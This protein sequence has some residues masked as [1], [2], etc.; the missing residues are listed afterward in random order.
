MS[1]ITSSFG[2]A[3][4][5]IRKIWLKEFHYFR[6]NHPIFILLF[7]AIF[8]V[9]YNVSWHKLPPSVEGSSDFLKIFDNFRVTKHK[10]VRMMICIPSSVVDYRFSTVAEAIHLTHLDFPEL[11]F[12]RDLDVAKKKLESGDIDILIHF[13]TLIETGKLIEYNIISQSGDL[14]K[15]YCIHC[16]HRRKQSWGNAVEAQQIVNRFLYWL[17]KARGFVTRTPH[18]QLS[19]VYIEGVDSDPMYAKRQTDLFFAWLMLLPICSR[20]IDSWNDDRKS[21]FYKIL[22]SLKIRRFEYFIAK[23]QFWYG[24]SLILSCIVFVVNVSVVSGVFTSTYLPFLIVYVACIFAFTIF[25]ATLFPESPFFAKFVGALL[26]AAGEFGFGTVLHGMAFFQLSVRFFGK[27]NV[28]AHWDDAVALMCMSFNFVLLLALSIYLDTFFFSYS[29]EPLK[30]YFPLER[31]Y[32]MPLSRSPQVDKHH[33]DQILS[34]SQDVALNNKK[35]GDKEVESKN[36]EQKTKTSNI[37]LIVL[38]GVCKRIKNNWKV[39]QLSLTIRYGEILTLYGHHGCGGEEILAIISGEMKPEYGEVMREKS[40]RELMVARSSHVPSVNYLNVKQYLRLVSQMRE[41]SVPE[42]VLDEMLAELDLTKVDRRSLDLLSTTQRERLRIAAAFVGQPDVVLIDWPTQESLPEWKYMILN[43]IEKRKEKKAIVMTSYDAEE[44]EAISD[45]VVLLSEGYVILNGACDNY[46]QSMSSVFEIRLWPVTFFTNEQI[47]KIISA[48]SMGDDQ[49]R[50]NA[51]YFETPNGKLRITLPLTYRKCIALMIMELENCAQEC[52]IAFY[53]LS[54]PNIHDVYTNACYEPQQYRPLKNYEQLDQLYAKQKTISRTRYFFKNMVRI[55]KDRQFLYQAAAVVGLFV[56]LGL[57]TLISHQKMHSHYTHEVSLD[58]HDYPIKIYCEH[59]VHESSKNAEYERFLGKN[60]LE[61]N[62]A[63]LFWKNNSVKADEELVAISHGDDTFTMVIQNFAVSQIIA[64]MT[65]HYPKITPF[66]ESEEFR[67]S[68]AAHGFSLIFNDV[69]KN[70]A[71]MILSESHSLMY[72]LGVFQT[73]IYVLSVLLPLRL[74]AVNMRPDSMLFPWPRYLYFGLIFTANLAIFLVFSIVLLL[75]LLSMDYFQTDTVSCFIQFLGAWTVS[76]ASTLPL[77]YLLVFNVN[78][79][80][81]IIPTVMA[82]SSLLVN[83]PNMVSSYSAEN[84]IALR[85][86]LKFVSWTCMLSPPTSLQVLAAFLNAGEFHDENRGTI[87]ALTAFCFAHSWT[88][89]VFAVSVFQPGFAHFR[90]FWFISTTTLWSNFERGTTLTPGARMKNSFLF[91]AQDPKSSAPTKRSSA[92]EQ[93]LESTSPDAKDLENKE[94]PDRQ[95]AAGDEKETPSK[96]SSIISGAERS[97]SNQED[98]SLITRY[99]EHLC[100]KVATMR[101]WNN[102]VDVPIDNHITYILGDS[103]HLKSALLRTIAEMNRKEQ[104]AYVPVVEC[105]PTIYTPREL[106]ENVAACHG[107]EVTELH[108]DYLLEAFG[109][110]ILECTPISL[111]TDADR[112]ILMLLTKLVIKPSII[113]LDQLDQFLP[114]SKIMTVW[115]LCSVLRSDGVSVIF[116]SRHNSFAEH[117]ATSCAHMHKCEIINT[118]P[119]STIK[120]SMGCT[121]VEVTA[122]PSAQAVKPNEKKE[123]EGAKNPRRNYETDGMSEKIWTVLKLALGNQ[124]VS[125]PSTK[126][127]IVVMVQGDTHNVVDHIIK[128]IGTL[129]PLIQHY[130]IRN[131]TFDEYIASAF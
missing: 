77:I 124:I 81:A 109:M 6:S 47:G 9:I 98:M 102:Q 62:N 64:K 112:R 40:Q 76:F 22:F 20:L 1:S 21:G 35:S 130:S 67:A 8:A 53:E 59:C 66:L 118:L 94:S 107:F 96:L 3:R 10:F 110:K 28:E 89:V 71:A 84:A 75:I 100:Q 14:N 82:V 85:T 43:F 126:G 86:L 12:V 55:L 46:K 56:F 54:K 69:N 13:T 83:L 92:P 45:R 97:S 50:N 16:D 121:I 32:W 25:L 36:E 68:S 104:I 108:I 38:Y 99:E 117:I 2:L 93:K 4:R 29:H 101:K 17:I 128:V 129:T 5:S 30:F 44:T 41:V 58:A 115:A 52:Q 73:F 23:F 70:Q 33:V 63:Y 24:I 31:A 87:A 11:E 26:M 48:I 37:P 123:K 57:L 42:A 88:L 127:K 103:T 60:E 106:L 80:A 119:P 131:G 19:H 78:T 51:K 15:H 39:N 90:Q 114:H 105:L 34:P 61:P 95:G 122:K 65:G 111:L 7:I 72:I 91:A 74:I 113:I 18:L 120:A 49:T 116:T 27:S 79:A 125:M